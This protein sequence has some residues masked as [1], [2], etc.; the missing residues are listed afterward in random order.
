[1]TEIIILGISSN[2]ML[3]K[4]VTL[5]YVI[6]LEFAQLLSHKFL[7]LSLAKTWLQGIF[8]TYI[9]VTN[10]CIKEML[11]ESCGVLVFF[12][13]GISLIENETKVV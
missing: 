5:K 6:L 2:A 12:F 9:F 11:S 7:I 13:K 8:F 3:M 1:M 4:P 10:I